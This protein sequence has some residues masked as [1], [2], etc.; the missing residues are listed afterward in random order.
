[1]SGF[2]PNMNGFFQNVTGLVFPNMAGFHKM[3]YPLYFFIFQMG[4]AQ[5]G[6][7]V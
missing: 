3:D 2:I 1:M 5:Q 6:L 7:L 4:P